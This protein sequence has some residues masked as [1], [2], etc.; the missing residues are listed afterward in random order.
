MRIQMEHPAIV[1][2][3]KRSD[4]EADY[5]LVKTISDIDVMELSS[6]EANVA[7]LIHHHGADTT[8][9]RVGTNFYKS[10]DTM[11]AKG[12]AL[13]KNMAM[14]IITQERY[15][16][17][18]FMRKIQDE[19][20]S[21]AKDN[22]PFLS[23]VAN[24]VKQTTRRE[25]KKGITANTKAYEKAPVLGTQTWLTPDA[26]EEV[27]TWARLFEE[28]M[29]NVV[30]VDG[31]VHVR[32]FEPCYSMTLYDDA[33][34]Q[35]VVYARFAKPTL[36]YVDRRK[37]RDIPELGLGGDQL[38]T[39]H[40]S[41]LE[42]DVALEFSAHFGVKKQ[43]DE[44]R[45]TKGVTVVD[46]AAMSPDFLHEE[47]VR[48]AVNSLTLSTQETE[49]LIKHGYAHRTSK[50][51]LAVRVADFEALERPIKELLA[52]SDYDDVTLEAATRPLIEMLCAPSEIVRHEK[53]IKVIANLARAQTYL[54]VRREIMPIEIISHGNVANH[55]T[56]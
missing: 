20:I 13:G 41:L 9:R 4:D 27:A 36:D 49:Q 16:F 40:F 55:A 33:F 48:L 7:V 22:D 21:L 37:V 39:Q 8:V 32:C 6:G 10:M 52:T 44:Y 35:D 25:E 12:L 11:S 42:S 15:H 3:R 30:L 46:P 29:E 54:D 38:V 45:N 17:Q 34:S 51:A 5:A 56:I 23:N 24:L 43:M 53:T 31:I 14:S 19:A 28:H 50:D 1:S 18:S 47:T 26:D 2:R